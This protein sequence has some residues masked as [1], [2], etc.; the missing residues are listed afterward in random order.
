[1]LVFCIT[2]TT[3]SSAGAI[4]VFLGVIA[5]AL[6]GM[7]L[8]MPNHLLNEPSPE[9]AAALRFQQKYPPVERENFYVVTPGM[10]DEWTDRPGAWCFEPLP[11]GSEVCKTAPAGDTEMPDI[12]LDD[13]SLFEMPR[14]GFEVDKKLEEERRLQEDPAALALAA[15]QEVALSA[16]DLKKV[17]LNSSYTK[18]VY[19]Q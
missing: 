6:F 12:D 1:M 4:L 5:S 3:T 19:A 2:S 18:R 14:S 17:R 13:D 10:V 11:F 16:S 8:L 9:V 7:A 15:K